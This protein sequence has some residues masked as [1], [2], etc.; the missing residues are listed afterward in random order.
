MTGRELFY[1]KHTVIEFVA[2]AQTH[3]EH[4]NSMGS[5]T[6]GAICLGPTG[7][8]QGSHYFMSLTS[9]SRI[10]RRV[11]TELPMPMDVINR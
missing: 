9:G 10:T 1:N 8:S 5:K 6:L 4:N 7:N 2:Y 3:E 11:W